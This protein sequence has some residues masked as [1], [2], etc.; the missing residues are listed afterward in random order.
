MQEHAVRCQSLAW[1]LFHKPAKVR[2][3]LRVKSSSRGLDSL[4]LDPVQTALSFRRDLPRLL[5]F[6]RAA[7]AGRRRPASRTC[8]LWCDVPGRRRLSLHGRCSQA[9]H[10]ACVFRQSGDCASRSRPHV[11]IG[12]HVS[13]R[14]V[15]MVTYRSELFVRFLA[16]SSSEKRLLSPCVHPP[17]PLYFRV[18]CF[19]ASWTVR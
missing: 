11:A 4:S 14:G 16:H 13:K 12:C 1:P 3:A 9:K 18:L 7:L 10:R 5:C 2:I 8:M 6:S 17:P 15:K 19:A